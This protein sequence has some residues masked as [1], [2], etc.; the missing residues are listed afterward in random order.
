MLRRSIDYVVM[1]LMLIVR[2]DSRC[3]RRRPPLDSPIM[4]TSPANS[5][6]TPLNPWASAYEY[7]VDA[8]QRSI[9]YADVMRQRG[10][11]YHSHMAKRAP[12][13]LSMKSELVLDG[14]EF[15]RPVNYGLLR[16]LPPVVVAV[17]PQKRP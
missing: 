1:G 7:A 3:C 4:T 16:I 8:L 10:N 14:R 15:A 11:Q 2:R 6:A 13:V 12:N 5:P 17:D 9:L